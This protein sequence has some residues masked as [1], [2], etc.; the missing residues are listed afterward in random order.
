ML[1]CLWYTGRATESEEKIQKRLANAVKEIAYA[2]ANNGAHFDAIIMNDN[3]EK[4]Y[5]QLKEAIKETL[6]AIPPPP[7]AVMDVICCRC[8]DLGDGPC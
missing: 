3:L 6:D 1:R 5:A 2:D 4:A 8:T 7:P